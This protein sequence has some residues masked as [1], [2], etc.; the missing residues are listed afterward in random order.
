[1]SK[2]NLAWMIYRRT[3]VAF[4][5]TGFIIMYSLYVGILNT[6]VLLIAVSVFFAEMFGVC[7]NDYHDIDEDL[8]NKRTDKMIVNN[9]LTCRQMKFISVCMFFASIAAS[10]FSG[11]LP[12]IV[13]YLLMAFLYSNP[14]V[15]LK[16]YTIKGYLTVAS[17]WLLIP[18]YMGVTLRG[19]L[20]LIDVFFAMFFFFQYT[21]LL[22]QKDST[23]PKDKTNLFIRS[24]WKRA[25]A[26]CTALGFL[27]SLFLFMVS[28]ASV[29]L[30]MVWGIN[31][32]VKVGQN[33]RVHMKRIDRSSRSNFTLM[34]FLT[35][36]IWIGGAFV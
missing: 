22:S 7:Y 18:L 14:K 36:Y 3:R 9:T 30:L 15:R 13:L 6:T 1:M 28:F 8:M 2:V 20:N 17:T 31:L 11:F 19:M 12:L 29:P 10:A 32:A 33:H 35:H 4:A 21:Y 23:D 25:S 34:E 5:F 27:S 26:I 16:K 24:G